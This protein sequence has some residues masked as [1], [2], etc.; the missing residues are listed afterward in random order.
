MGTIKRNLYSLQAGVDNNNNSIISALHTD[1]QQVKTDISNL[2]K[3][4]T[5]VTTKDLPSTTADPTISSQIT[6]LTRRPLTTLAVSAWNCRGLTSAT[7]YI[8][9]LSS[10]SDIIVLSEHWLWPYELFKLDNLMEDFSSFGCSDKRLTEHSALTR[11]CGGVA[12]LWRN[13]LKAT[14]VTSITSDRIVAIQLPLPNS[15]SLSIIGV[16]LP[17]TDHPTPEYTEYL[18][19]LETIVTALQSEGPVIVAGDFNA[20]IGTL[21]CGRGRDPPNH[22][23][24][25]LLDVIC[26]CDLFVASLLEDAAGADYTYAEGSHR[27][28][29]DYC[30]TDSCLAHS[31]TSCTTLLPDMLNLSDH[32]P[33]TARFDIQSA[34]EPVAP[35]PSRLNWNR[36]KDDNSINLFSDQMM[37]FLSTVLQH[38]TP[39]SIEELDAEIAK[40]CKFIV[41][42]AR[43]FIPSFKPGKKKHKFY[44]DDT[45]AQL[46]RGSKA[47]WRVW[48][49]ADLVPFMM[50][51]N[52]LNRR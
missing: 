45:L 43:I 48:R 22:T 24:R 13:H 23:G 34:I 9:H 39:G 1:L 20:H 3:A 16:Y 30:I 49:D 42:S 28:T 19:E 18:L 36:A 41:D 29:V 17:S 10:S 33:I 46:C 38:P 52:R 21:G 50:T 31:I 37:S 11:G 40:V 14:P 5:R 2:Q 27:T 44:R 12:I 35:I 6:P 15:Q 26:R 8:Q 25:L 32:L 4:N 47:N 7:P 51:S